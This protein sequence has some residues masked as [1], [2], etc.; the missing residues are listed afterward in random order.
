[1]R[2]AFAD[3]KKVVLKRGRG[4]LFRNGNPLVYQKSI[5]CVIGGKPAGG[6][7]VLVLNAGRNLLGWG[8]YN[9]YSMFHVRWVAAL[10]GTRTDRHRLHPTRQAFS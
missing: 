7:P 6:F 10:G 2:Y 5:D 3:A 4:R 9:P 8:F 1:M